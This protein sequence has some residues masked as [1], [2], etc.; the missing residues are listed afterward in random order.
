MVD[1]LVDSGTFF[2]SIAQD[3]LDKIKQK[4]PNIIIKIDDPPKFQIQVTNGQLENHYQQ[5][6]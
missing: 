3:D 4:A 2:S 5:P 6:H 1:A